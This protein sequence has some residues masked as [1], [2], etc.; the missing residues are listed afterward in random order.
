MTARRTT[1]SDDDSELVDDAL[2]G[3]GSAGET[4]V[5]RGVCRTTLAEPPTLAGPRAAWSL[6]TLLAVA[7]AEGTILSP[8][9]R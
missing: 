6:S 1:A 5:S 4:N 7:V 9:S 8:S 3:V 2:G